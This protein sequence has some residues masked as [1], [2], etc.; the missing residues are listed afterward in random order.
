MEFY[1]DFVSLVLLVL[2]SI[3]WGIIGMLFAIPDLLNKPK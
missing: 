2:G 1:D 3:Q